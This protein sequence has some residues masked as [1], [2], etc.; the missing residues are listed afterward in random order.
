MDAT[1]APLPPQRPD[2][3]DAIPHQQAAPSSYHATRSVDG[4]FVS[5][6]YWFAKKVFRIKRPSEDEGGI[7]HNNQEIAGPTVYAMQASTT[8]DI[9]AA[10]TASTSQ[11][12]ASPV[13]KP[14]PDYAK[15]GDVG[16]GSTDSEPLGGRLDRVKE[17]IH[18][19]N[20]LPWVATD[21]VTVDYYPGKSKKKPQIKQRPLQSPRHVRSWYSERGD[22]LPF[23]SLRHENSQSQQ[24]PMPLSSS[25]A[26]H[27][28]TWSQNGNV[29]RIYPTGYVPAAQQQDGHEPS[30]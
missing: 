4:A 12:H 5:V 6:Y 24:D 28:V 8:V 7:K 1:L 27:D 20:D 15:M 3:M 23:T 11:S 26:D 9:E 14:G 22:V 18:Q 13:L 25:T 30:A 2:V 17:F 29:G 21:R 16:S 19:V 10:D